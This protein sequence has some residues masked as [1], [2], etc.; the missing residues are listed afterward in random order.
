MRWLEGIIN[1]MDISSIKQ[2][3][4]DSEGQRKLGVLQSTGL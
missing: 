4:G 2:I 3:P 1:S